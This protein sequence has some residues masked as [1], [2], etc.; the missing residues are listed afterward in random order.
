MVHTV[1]AGGGPLPQLV[2]LVGTFAPDVH[3]G[4][5][6]GHGTSPFRQQS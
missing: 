2:T 4:F 6:S 5:A 1:D 3:V